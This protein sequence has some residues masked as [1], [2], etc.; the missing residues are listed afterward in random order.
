MCAKPLGVALAVL[1]KVLNYL[2]R[3][4]RWDPETER[5]TET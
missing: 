5:L 1:V 2:S 4:A 3:R